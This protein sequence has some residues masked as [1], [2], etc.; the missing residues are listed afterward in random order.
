[1]KNKLCLAIVFL[2]LFSNQAYS[3]NDKSQPEPSFQF[4]GFIPPKDKECIPSGNQEGPSF[5]NQDTC[6]LGSYPYLERNL[7]MTRKD[8]EEKLTSLLEYETG[9]YKLTKKNI[10]DYDLINFE[11]KFPTN[12]VGIKNYETIIKATYILKNDV[13]IGYQII[14]PFNISE[15]DSKDYTDSKISIIKSLK[16][17]NIINTKDLK[18]N[19]YT[20]KKDDFIETYCLVDLFYK[21]EGK[22]N[23][24]YYVD[25]FYPKKLKKE[26]RSILQD[27]LKFTFGITKFDYKDEDDG[28]DKD[29][30]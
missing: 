2:V 27:D 14:D 22:Y 20:K 18:I 12:F 24:W 11:R 17:N 23:L 15:F 30:D 28:D 1:M 6:I 29:D 10:I 8:L 21:D 7:K 5:L 4:N 13:V 19:F 25:S 3:K 9:D 26:L 16:R